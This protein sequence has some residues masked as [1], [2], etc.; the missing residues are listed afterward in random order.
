MNESYIPERWEFIQFED[1]ISKKE[2]YQISSYG[3]VK[4]FKVDSENGI[5]IK[6]F[7]VGGYL[8]LPIKQ[9]NEKRTARY[10]HKLVATTFL[11][12]DDDSQTFVIHLD[13]GKDNNHTWNLAWATK[14]EKEVHQFSN[15]K[16]EAPSNRIRYSKLNEGRV[17]IIKRKLND[18]NRRTR[19]K[20]I[21]K[22][23]GITEMQLHRIKTGENWGW[24]KVD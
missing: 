24:V 22:T 5:L 20:M 16:Y 3:R 14:K 2:K 11:I 17:K 19:L 4:S 23:Y 10:I 9:K 8:R 1:H 6:L 15:P 7:K 13:Y 12:K 21:A 18:P